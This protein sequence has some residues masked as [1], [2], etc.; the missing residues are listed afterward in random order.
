MLL[1]NSIIMNS[2]SLLSLKRNVFSQF[3]MC[4]YPL[5]FLDMNC[6]S[7]ASASIFEALVKF[8]SGEFVTIFVCDDILT[9]YFSL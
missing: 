9:K 5:P 2:N 6:L 3:Y 1:V 4:S 7:T 8:F